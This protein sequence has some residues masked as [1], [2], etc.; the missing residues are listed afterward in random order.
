MNIDFTDEEMLAYRERLM[1]KKK[2]QPFW[3]KKCLTV[4]E[5]AAYT[6]VGRGKIRELMKMKDC[7]F[8]M[9]DGYQMYV[10]IEKFVEYLN[11]RNEI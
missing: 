11:S 1:E 10:V 4:N 9:T 6:G 2:E 8:I 5:T 7:K 3:K